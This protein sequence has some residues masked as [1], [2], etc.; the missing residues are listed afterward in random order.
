MHVIWHDDKIVH[1]E[2]SRGHIRAQNIDQ[3][4]RVPFRL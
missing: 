1:F 3:Q 4:R 2:F